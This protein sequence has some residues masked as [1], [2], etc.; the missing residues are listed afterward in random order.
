MPFFANIFKGKDAAARRHARENG[1][2]QLE[3]AKPQRW[4][5]AWQRKEIEP[6]EVQELLSCCTQEIKS[7]GERS[8][9]IRCRRAAG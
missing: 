3:P 6:E 7:R 2:A 8:V 9:G 5:D 1:A 4:D